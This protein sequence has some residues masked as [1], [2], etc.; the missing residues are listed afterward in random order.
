MDKGEVFTGDPPKQEHV[1]DQGVR[2]G[3]EGFLYVQHNPPS[4]Q[5]RMAGIPVKDISNGGGG[6]SPL[7]KAFL[8]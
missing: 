8:V 2:H 5:V 4:M 7:S 3:I 1:V 6:A